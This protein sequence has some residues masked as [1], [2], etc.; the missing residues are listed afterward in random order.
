MGHTS[1]VNYES[2]PMGVEV[3]EENNTT[4][5]PPVIESPPP[6]SIEETPEECE[7]S[8][9]DDPNDTTSK[10]STRLVKFQLFETKAV[11]PSSIQLT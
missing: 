9:I 2:V 6:P 11:S 4:G 3:V 1:A 7:Q 10:T 5:Q 8:S